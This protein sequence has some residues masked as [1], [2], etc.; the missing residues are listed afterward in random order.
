MR[1]K[2]G[3]LTLAMVILAAFIGGC[4][5]SPDIQEVRPDPL[6]LWNDGAAKEQIIGFVDDIS[7]FFSDSLVPVEERIAVF[8]NDGTLWPEKPLY[9]PLEFI[10]DLIEEMAE[11]HPAWKTEEPFRWV[12]E[13]NYSAISTEDF[14]ALIQAT[15]GGMTQREFSRL[16]RKWLRTAEHPRFE[17]KYK[18]LAYIPM[19][20]LLEYLRKN[21]F[22]IFICS[23]GTAEFI[24][25]YSG[26]A[27]KIPPEQVIG[28]TIDTRFEITDKGPVLFRTGNIVPPLN[29][30][31]GKPVNIQRYI[32]LR[33]IIAFGNSD[34]D[35]QMLQYTT[36]G[37]GP[38][39]GVLL[40]HD[41]AERAY[42]YD[43]GTEKALELAKENGWTVVSMKND[44]KMVFPEK[45]EDK[46][47]SSDQPST[48]SGQGDR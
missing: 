35:I 27:Y 47:E 11:E 48:G 45:D 28:T 41:D 20:Q 4:S 23:G 19:L 42:S 12:L 18:K 44:F 2:Y 33:P 26:L 15:H 31:E 43:E 7:D 37:R 13:E 22:K 8:D 5:S 40:H 39:L 32:G 25:A 17:E 16:A 6:P 14:P 34:G 3:T 10:F 46:A 38:G 21:G 29:D 36:E 30:R 1:G 9:F 24:R